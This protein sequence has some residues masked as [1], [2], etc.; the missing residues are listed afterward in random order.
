MVELSEEFEDAYDSI[1]EKAVK[2]PHHVPRVKFGKIPL[3][4]EGFEPES[5][6]LVPRSAPVTP[7]IN[8][9]A[10]FNFE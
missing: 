10:L 1:T 4:P 6:A 7:G 5:P 2:D 9:E 3:G 8:Y